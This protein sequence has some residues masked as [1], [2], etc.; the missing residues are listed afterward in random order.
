M[1]LTGGCLCG[2]I[3]YEI[4]GA[5][6]RVINC[7]CEDCRKAGGAMAHTGVVVEKSR[8][9]LSRGAPKTFEGVGRSGHRIL[10]HFCGI[11]GSGIYNEPGSAPQILAVKAGTLDDPSGLAPSYEIFAGGK[12]DW[13]EAKSVTESFPQMRPAK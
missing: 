12:P 9:L 11:C 8:F 2:A 5:P 1:D 10:R 3:R 6:L 4:I 7:Y 13:F